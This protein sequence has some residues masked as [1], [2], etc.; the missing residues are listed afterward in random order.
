MIR[1]QKSIPM[2]SEETRRK[3]AQL[4]G[5]FSFALPLSFAAV[6][7]CASAS[8]A[9]KTRSPL[10][11]AGNPSFGRVEETGATI[12]VAG[13]HKKFRIRIADIRFVNV[14]RRSFPLLLLRPP[15]F[16][17]SCTLF[18]FDLIYLDSTIFIFVLRYE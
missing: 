18:H 15:I 6:R 13:T 11:G 14:S 9:K 1:P 3:P 16:P 17:G 7:R 12:A 10:P 4:R 8:P 5:L 2:G